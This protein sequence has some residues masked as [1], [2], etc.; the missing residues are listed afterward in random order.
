MLDFDAKHVQGVIILLE[1][2][3]KLLVQLTSRK[4]PLERKEVPRVKIVSVFRIESWIS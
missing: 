1:V 3:V 2:P 4:H